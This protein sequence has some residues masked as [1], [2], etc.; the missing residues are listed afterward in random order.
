MRHEGSKQ[1]L[2]RELKIKQLGQVGYDTLEKRARSIV[3][4]ADAIKE[5]VDYL[6]HGPLTQKTTGA[7]KERQ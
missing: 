2:Y 1:G 4:R 3:K 6:G 7:T 5:C